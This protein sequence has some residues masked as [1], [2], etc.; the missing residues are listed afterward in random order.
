M[1]RCSLLK[2][3]SKKKTETISL[4]QFLNIIFLDQLELIIQD[5]KVIF[6]SQAIF[7]F[8]IKDFVP[9]LFLFLINF[10]FIKR[11]SYLFKLLYDF[12]RT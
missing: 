6:L 7:I 12:D 4:K 5:N 9:D 2:I 1:L 8:L 10:S 11:D 3:I